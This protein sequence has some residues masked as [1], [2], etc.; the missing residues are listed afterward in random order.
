[1]KLP[2][3]HAPIYALSFALCAFVVIEYDEF[4]KV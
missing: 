3:H 1:M 2:T 4:I